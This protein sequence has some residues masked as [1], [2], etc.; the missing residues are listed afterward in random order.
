[1]QIRAEQTRKALISA[2]AGLIDLKGLR[3]TG[4]VEVSNAAGVSKGALYFHFSCKEGLASAVH[5]ET[6]QRV[7]R[8]AERH[9]CGP[10]PDLATL[11]R[12]LTQLFAELREDTT[13]RAGLRLESEDRAADGEGPLPL[14]Q[15]WLRYLD[16]HFTFPGDLAALPH[17]LAAVTVGLEVLGRKDAHWWT[18]ETVDGVW[19]LLLRLVPQSP[20]SE[21]A[22]R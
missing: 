19:E 9:L 12:F 21:P 22:D 11:A 10:D 8:L 16:R 6:H 13:L 20:E 3:D 17:L 15:A 4:L 2:A 7:R 5:E 18:E 14:R 1:M